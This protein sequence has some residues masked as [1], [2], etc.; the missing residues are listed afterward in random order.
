MKGTHEAV[1]VSAPDLA[2]FASEAHGGLERWN[3]FTTLSAHLIQGS[4]LWA[5]EGKAG[6]LA[7]GRLG[8]PNPRTQSDFRQPVSL[9]CYYQI[10]LANEESN[11]QSRVVWPRG[12]AYNRDER[13]RGKLAESGSPRLSSLRKGL[14]M[15]P[16]FAVLLA[17][18]ALVT[19]SMVAADNR[20]DPGADVAVSSPP[21]PEFAPMTRSE[22]LSNYLV[23]IAD[24]ESFIR[25]AASAGIA[26]A[27]GTPK[28][29]GGGA[30]GF[31]ERMGNAYAQ[32]V[33]HR[34][35]LY[36]ISAALHEDNRYFVSG[37]AGF[38]RRTKYAV[39]STL[40]ARHDNGSQSFSF[41]RIGSAAGTAFISRAWQPRSTTSAGDGAASF[42]I[43]L[44]SDIG[45]NLFREFWPD[46]KRHFRKE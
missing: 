9:K 44:G 43:N 39:K 18:G 4:V 12:F 6:V 24:G 38:F 35:L 17:L 31:G 1:E 16:R 32:H 27:K 36:G 46:L 5:S 34:T 10:S 19:T 29:W 41:S 11:S 21:P 7:D 20:P 37:Q 26:Q 22:R 8:A 14:S 13:Y 42:G 15:A 25:A 45:F 28:E 40:L 30:E 23:G 2:K 33:I 3:G